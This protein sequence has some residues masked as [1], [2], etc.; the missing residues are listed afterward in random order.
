MFWFYGIVC[1]QGRLGY[2]RNRYLLYT[3]DVLNFSDARELH[4]YMKLIMQYILF[5]DGTVCK[6]RR[7]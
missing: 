5:L 6:Q 7:L 2:G 1:E 4:V 3:D